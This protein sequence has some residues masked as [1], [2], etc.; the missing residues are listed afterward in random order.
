[1]AR[2]SPVSQFDYPIVRPHLPAP[3]EWLPYLAES[4]RQHWFS[5]FG[6]VAT[7]LEASLAG[8]FGAPG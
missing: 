6:P 8:R 5:N 2:G 4:Y 1:M 7:R 3:A